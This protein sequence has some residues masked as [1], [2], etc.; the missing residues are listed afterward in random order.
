VKRRLKR[1]L[2]RAIG[3]CFQSPFDHNSRPCD[4]PRYV[5]LLEAPRAKRLTVKRLSGCL[6]LRPPS[7]WQKAGLMR[8]SIPLVMGIIL[9]VTLVTVQ[10][11]QLSFLFSSSAQAPWGA[12]HRLKINIMD[13]LILLVAA[14]WLS[15]PCLIGPHISQPRRD[16]AILHAAGQ[17]ST[18]SLGHS[19]FTSEASKDWPWPPSLR[20]ARLKLPLNAGLIESASPLSCLR[21]AFNSID[22]PLRCLAFAVYR[23]TLNTG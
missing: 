8:L 3:R 20:R 19:A 10:V 11:Q 5:T 2:K 1:R 12:V 14:A 22:L 15:L 6:T 16:A 7:E 23:C 17:H 18:F 13:S 9:L 4:W 21:R